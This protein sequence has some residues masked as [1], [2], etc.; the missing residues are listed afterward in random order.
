MHIAHMQTDTHGYLLAW[1][2]DLSQPSQITPL[3]QLHQ[4]EG[5]HSMDSLPA[6]DSLCVLSLFHTARFIGKPAGS[7]APP[8]QCESRGGQYAMTC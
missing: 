7:A 5:S 3:P 2:Y 6:V 4:Y 8:L 1:H